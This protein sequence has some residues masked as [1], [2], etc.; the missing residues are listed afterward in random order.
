MINNLVSEIEKSEQEMIATFDAMD[1]EKLLLDSINKDPCARKNN[2]EFEVDLYFSNKKFSHSVKFNKL[3][4]IEIF[5]FVVNFLLADGDIK[6]RLIL[7][8]TTSDLEKF[9]AILKLNHDFS[10]G[11]IEYR[12]T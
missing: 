10:V 1:L 4:S 11:D 12:V 6:K 3:H 5:S 2:N 7:E 8:V 9:I